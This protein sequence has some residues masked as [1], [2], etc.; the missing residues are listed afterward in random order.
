MSKFVKPGNGLPSAV[1]ENPPIPFVSKVKKVE[2]AEGA[3]VDKTEHIKLEF[4]MDPGNPASKYARHFVIFKD[5]CPEDWIKWLM[6]FREIENLMPLKEPADKTKMFRT[7]LKGQALSYFEHHLRKR[8]DAEDAELPDNDLLELVIRDIGLEYIPRRAIRVQKYYMR[9]GLF[10]GPSTSVQQFVERLNDL[11]RYLLYFPEE[12]PKQLDQDEIIEILDQAKAPEWHEAMVAANIDIFEMSYEESVSYFKRLENLEKIR[13]T[14]GPA[15]TLPVDN[16]KHV[17]SSVGKARK[18]SNQW[19]HYC[20]K[21]NHNTADCQ[22]IAKAKQ[23][24]KVH[25]EAKA[26]PGKKSLAFLF[27]E[28]NAIKRQLKPAKIAASKKRKV[29]SLLSTEINLTT[30]S[31]EDEEYFVTSPNF[32]RPSKPKLAKTSHPT[33]ELV[34]SLTVNQEEHLLRALADTGASSSIILEAYTS[35]HLIKNDDE[36]KTTWSTMG[37]QFTTDKSGLVTFSL[38]EFNLR[39]QI[40]W[41]F[42]VDDRSESS[43]TSDMIIGR[44]LLGELGIILNFND[45]TVTWDTD[46]IPMKDRGTLATQESLIEVYLSANEPQTLVDEF[47]RSTKIL[48]AEYKPAILDEVIKMCENLNQEEQHQ[49][50][51]ILQKYEHLFDGTLGEFNMEPISLHLMDKGCKPVHARPYTVPRSVEQQL[52]KEI[53]RLVEIGVLEEDYTS[54]WASPTF[55]IAK[56]NGTIRVVSDFRKLNSLLKRHPFPIPKIGDMI[57]S[58]EGFTF[59]TA[60]D[61]NMGYYHIKLDADAQRLCTIVF[62]WGKY[63]YKRLPMGI[64]IAPDVFQNVMSKLTQDM[65]YVK[66]YLDDLLILTNNTFKDHLLKLELVLARLSTAGMRVNASKSK[67][68][69]E[70]IEYLGYWITRQGIQPV[71]NKIEAILKI[72]T[73]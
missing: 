13:R 60:L 64:K 45:K 7:L 65:E 41:V 37:G 18:S 10:M 46:T 55:A 30:S 63:K 72:N 73:P 34:V 1:R 12:T 27:E 71:H 58:M 54:E 4:F 66:T 3:E 25:F 24:K 33:S 53:A 44:D 42:H 11:N 20:D 70:Q 68:F 16:K 26:V 43:S 6:A 59:A 56:K 49:L 47:S 2:K 48:D 62:P 22:A 67:F 51:Q 35:R 39:K 21:N 9:R 19:C 28:I 23:Q 17:T 69:A 8:L 36:N 57:R 61:L 31:D 32:F 50:L 5:G 38:P 15:P 52:R 14:N 40:S 29:E